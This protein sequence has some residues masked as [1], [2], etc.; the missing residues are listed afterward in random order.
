MRYAFRPLMRLLETFRRAGG[1]LIW[2][3]STKM[4]HYLSTKPKKKDWSDNFSIIDGQLKK[5]W[6]SSRQMWVALYY[7]EIRDFDCT[8]KRRIIGIKTKQASSF[9]LPLPQIALE[10]VIFSKK[11]E[12]NGSGVLGFMNWNTIDTDD[13]FHIGPGE[14]VF[15]GPSRS[16]LVFTKRSS[17]GKP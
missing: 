8:F 12:K 5:K 6:Q 13:C 2:L 16:V 3:G 7:C 1:L 14:P 17:H 4:R 15:G 9:S 10:V 11:L